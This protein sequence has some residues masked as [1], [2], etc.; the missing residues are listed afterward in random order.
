M[1]FR[2]YTYLSTVGVGEY[3]SN[4]L[5][6]MIWINN[7]GSNSNQIHYFNMGPGFG[8]APNTG[9]SSYGNAGQFRLRVQHRYGS[10]STF[11]ADQTF[12]FY[13]ASAL[14]GLN[15]GVAG[16]QILIYGYLL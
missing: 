3:G 13:S 14:T 1:Y 5:S 16:R 6:N 4:R 15:P 11:P 8:H 7:F 12:E 2:I 10:D 9:D